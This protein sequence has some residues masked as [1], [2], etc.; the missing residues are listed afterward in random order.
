MMVGTKAIGRC[1]PAPQRAGVRE[2]GESRVPTCRQMTD[3]TEPSVTN[4][5]PPGSAP[6][7]D[8]QKKASPRA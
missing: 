1:P 3:K 4:T 2:G 6:Q 7:P 5:P 8:V